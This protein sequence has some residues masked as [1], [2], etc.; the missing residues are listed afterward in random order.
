MQQRKNMQSKIIKIIICLTSL[1][2]SVMAKDEFFQEQNKYKINM[3][4][5]SKE[6]KRLKKVIDKS[7]AEYKTIE[8]SIEGSSEGGTLTKYIDND[9]IVKIKAVY[10]S[11]FGKKEIEVYLKNKL[12]FLTID[13]DYIYSKPIYE[14]KNKVRKTVIDEYLFNGDSLIKWKHNHKDKDSNTYYSK[15]LE[16][17]SLTN[18]LIQK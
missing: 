10:Y 8:K 3:V 13:I 1:V 6:I 14:K 5:A 4:E 11:E 15:Y 2:V 9:K 18:E 17:I 12:V 7:I 16:I